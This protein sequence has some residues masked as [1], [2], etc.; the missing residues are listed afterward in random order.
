MR[1]RLLAAAAGL[2]LALFGAVAPASPASAHC[3]GHGTHPDLY[4]GGGI[5][6]KNG[7]NIRRYPHTNCA[8]DG[9]GCPSQGI[10]V[11]CA[12]ET[13][14]LW[15]FVRNTSTGV[16]GWSRFDALNYA[17]T[18]TIRDCARLAATHSVA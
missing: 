1:S 3:G 11:H 5:S 8:S 17:F 14:S 15:L 16:S 10:D 12:T 2:S 13:G 4:G 9:P 18:V 6:F 7:T